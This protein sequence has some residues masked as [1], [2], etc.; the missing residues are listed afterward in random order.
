MAESTVGTRRSG[1]FAFK[2]LPV[3]WKLRAL[4][5]LVCV[6]M[7][8]VGL[9]GL[10]QLGKTQDRLKSLYDN[11]LHTIQLINTVST[12]VADVRRELLNLA[13]A[14]TPAENAQQKPVV[15][16]ALD[17]T[18]AAWA[19]FAATPPGNGVDERAEYVAPGRITRRR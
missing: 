18:A 2:H 14:Q 1:G 19:A 4:A 17:D 13:V 9:F 15:E 3:A 12:R 6:M 10:A 8:A 16:K 11:N 7:L 5:A